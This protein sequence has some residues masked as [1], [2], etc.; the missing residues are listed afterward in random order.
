MVFFL[1]ITRARAR[2]LFLKNSFSN[3]LKKRKEKKP[4]NRYLSVKI[5]FW[6]SRSIANP[7]S[8]VS[9][10]N[11]DFPIERTQVILCTGFNFKHEY[12]KMLQRAENVK[13]T[14]LEAMVKDRCR[15]SLLLRRKGEI[16]VQLS[17]NNWR[18]LCLPSGY[19]KTSLP[20]DNTNLV[21]LFALLL[22]LWR[23]LKHCDNKSV[24]CIASVV[25]QL[26]QMPL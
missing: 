5:C 13:L 24:P 10:L 23:L 4:K 2:P 14:I 9:N 21:D 3:P 26:L 17:E 22:F 1:L 15:W 25:Q 20:T 8:G 7:K 6:I 11:P 16:G 12:A 18:W 19:H